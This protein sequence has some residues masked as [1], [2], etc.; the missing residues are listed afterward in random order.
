MKAQ[1]TEALRQT[2]RPEFLN[3]I[4]EIIVFH[5]LT[6]EDLARIVDLLLADLPRTARGARPG[7]RAHARRPGA[8]SPR[9][10]HDPQF[11]ARPLKRA[12]QRL[13]ENPL[14]RALLE[15]RFPPGSTIKVDADPVSGTLLFTDGGEVVVAEAAE[16]R[17]ARAARRS[18]PRDALD[19]AIDEAAT[20]A[21]RKRDPDLLN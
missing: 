17:D 6:D 1:V 18:E 13:V 7:A 4:D 14:A 16:R 5:S 10:G 3:R 20:P 11:G 21:G 2:F 15:G 19:R 8:S 9:E 12:I